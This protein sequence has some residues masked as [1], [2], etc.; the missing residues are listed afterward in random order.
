M[1][2]KRSACFVVLMTVWTASVSYSGAYRETPTPN[3]PLSQ[4][5]SLMSQETTLRDLFDRWERVWHEGQYD[6]VA[7]CVQP[8]LHPARRSRRPDSN[9]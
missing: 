8:N 9:T 6:L 1:L 4:G 3:D 7:Q 5:K 2:N